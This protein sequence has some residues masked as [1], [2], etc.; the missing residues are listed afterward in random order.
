MDN[1]KSVRRDKFTRHWGQ[2]RP[3]SL[4]DAEVAVEEILR[5]VCGKMSLTKKRHTRTGT[6]KQKTRERICKRQGGNS[7]GLPPGADKTK[8]Q[9]K[10][11]TR[12]SW[13][14][15]ETTRSTPQPRHGRATEE[16]DILFTLV[17][18]ESVREEEEDCHIPQ[19][20]NEERDSVEGL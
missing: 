9:T 8:N 18:K 20:K 1:M 6:R 2:E 17:R 10:G 3:G 4:Q 5:D 15:C 14:D 16:M 13:Q 19:G 7:K 12:K 11:S